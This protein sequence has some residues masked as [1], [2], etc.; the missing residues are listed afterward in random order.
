MDLKACKE[1]SISRI[2]VRTGTNH[3]IRFY[4]QIPND[5]GEREHTID[6][7]QQFERSFWKKTNAPT[8]AHRRTP[9]Y[10]FI[11]CQI[12]QVNDL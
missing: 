9:E 10:L 11:K 4:H 12:K 7:H 8:K 2:A 6:Y 5:N 1:E 3:F